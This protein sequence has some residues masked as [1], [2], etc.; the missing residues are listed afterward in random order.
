MLNPEKVADNLS[1]SNAYIPGVRPGLD[2]QNYIARLMFKITLLGTV[3]L[4]I[5]AAMPIVTA[6]VFNFNAQES[7]AIVLGGT[8]LL[9]VV[10]VAM[11]TTNQ[12]E[13]EANN[14][15]YKGIF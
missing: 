5:L 10:G 9:I 12:I 6:I 11:E 1:K 13:T 7:Q 4:V 8:S 3:Y 15:E 2:T 14:Q